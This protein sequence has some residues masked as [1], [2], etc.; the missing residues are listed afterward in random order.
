[1]RRPRLGS[2]DNIT[3]NMYEKVK[4]RG[5]E[6]NTVDFYEFNVHFID[7]LD[8]LLV[9]GRFDKFT[10]NQMKFVE[11]FMTYCDGG[12]V[13]KPRGSSTVDN[14]DRGTTN[15]VIDPIVPKHVD[16][17]NEHETLNYLF[18]QILQVR[19]NKLKQNVLDFP[20]AWVYGESLESLKEV[21]NSLISLDDSW[22]ELSIESKI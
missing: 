13:Y 14:T 1:M 15:L 20:D 10:A 9:S 2:I 11:G 8:R 5:I 16:D 21:V 18:G 22:G 3:K 12:L 6:D 7:M 17:L 19:V 4:G